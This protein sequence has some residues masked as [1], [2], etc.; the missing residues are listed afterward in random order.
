MNEIIFDSRKSNTAHAAINATAFL[1]VLAILVIFWKKLEV[2]MVFG[3]A[4]GLLCSGFAAV[5]L[6]RGRKNIEDSYSIS[7]SASGIDM[8]SGSRLFLPAADIL[9][10]QVKEVEHHYSGDVDL[11]YAGKILLKSGDSI[12]IPIKPSDQYR[13][14]LLKKY[15]LANDYPYTEEKIVT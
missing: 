4:W 10:F 12:P 1:I 2:A 7:L 8:N 11:T 9:E 3:L 15:C 14:R 5:M 6:F 13:F